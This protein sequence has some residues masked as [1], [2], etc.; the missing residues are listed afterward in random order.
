M[1]LLDFL[2]GRTKPVPTTTSVQQ[3]SKLPEQI[4]PFVEEVLG[5]AQQL[6]GQR[7]EEGFKEF[8]GET[9]APRTAEELAALE[10]L[11]GLVGTQEPYRAEAEEVIRATPTQFT[12]D[13][14]QR[15]MSPYQR[16]VT[17]IEKREAQRSFERDVQPALEAKA[18][19]AGGMSGLGTRAGLQASEAQRAQSQLLAD[20]EAK[21]QQR[22]FEQ[23]YRQFGD[24]VNLQRQRAG[25]IQQQ[26]QQRF[27]IGLA[28]QGLQ[29]QIG[30]E[31]RAEAQALLNE[32]FAEFV[33]REQFPESTLAQYSS[34]VYGNPFL[35]QPDTTRTTTGELQPTTSLGQGLLNLGLTGLNIYGRGYTPQGF[36]MGQFGK[37]FTRAGGGRVGGGLAALPIVRRAIGGPSSPTGIPGYVP[38]GQP[39]AVQPPAPL[40]I[41][42]FLN[43]PELER[44]RRYLRE[45][46]KFPD[47][48]QLKSAREAYTKEGI[49]KPLRARDET[50][51]K[52]SKE[53]S[54]TADRLRDELEESQMARFKD[55]D[56]LSQPIAAAVQAV[57]APGME[58]KGF[59]NQLAAGLSQLSAEQ[60]KMKRTEGK[61]KAEAKKELIKLED[62]AANRAFDDR[63]LAAT[64]LAETQQQIKKAETADELNDLN[65]DKREQE[66]QL[67]VADNAADVLATLMDKETAMLNALAKK[68]KAGKLDDKDYK[69]V[70]AAVAKQFGFMLGEDGKTIMISKDEALSDKDPVFSRIEA[71][72]S[73]MVD[74]LEKSGKD[75]TELQKGMARIA[76]L[77]RKAKP[78]PLT[79]RGTPNRSVMK[80]GQS[81][82]T[83][84]GLFLFDGTG[85]IRIYG[86]T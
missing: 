7:R 71:A 59:I 74:L 10:G 17:D 20:I 41:Q 40:G 81:F 11:R 57:S 1:A 25:D 22:A 27:N 64:R 50:L 67:K 82:E 75:Y 3:S 86:S 70:R 63:Q 47:R 44:V 21:G 55:S 37:S 9:I 16:A 45:G 36:S 19:Q 24:E 56:M 51:K 66:Q 76:K 60:D 69:T 31:D 78:M 26:G 5:E 29:Q 14:A 61:E 15:L 35:R 54:S 33:E 49:I 39:A 8:P 30:Q 83:E 72:S 77:R 58:T 52:I 46:A 62:L 28:E 13:E 48:Q 65:Y 4:A 2:F 43:A 18:I 23:A 79:E 68:A 6:Y 38:T 34:F 12:A 32:Q 73:A 53:R 84:D 80:E 42:N 85:L